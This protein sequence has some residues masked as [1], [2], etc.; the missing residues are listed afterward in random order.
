MQIVIES[1]QGLT[2][3]PLLVFCYLEED[4]LFSYI[5]TSSEAFYMFEA[6]IQEFS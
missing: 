6:G 3:L 4:K 1:S 5:D 2:P